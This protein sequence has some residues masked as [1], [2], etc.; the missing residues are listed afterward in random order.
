MMWLASR[1]RGFV[2][3]NEDHVLQSMVETVHGS[4]YVI[5]T[6]ASRE[7]FPVTVNNFINLRHWTVFWS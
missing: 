6:E 5:S 4:P 7:L 1:M 2:Y 3:L